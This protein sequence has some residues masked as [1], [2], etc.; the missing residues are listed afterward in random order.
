[1]GL[2]QAGV[3]DDLSPTFTQFSRRLCC[4]RE[5]RG[6]NDARCAF[7]LRFPV[8]GRILS[9]EFAT[10]L[11]PVSLGREIRLLFCANH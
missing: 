11:E 8:C 3:K 6:I 9:L 5:R 1:M 2:G 7:M 4:W 10:F